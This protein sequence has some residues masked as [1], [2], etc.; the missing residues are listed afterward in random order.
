MTNSLVEK[1]AQEVLNDFNQYGFVK[2]S[3]VGSYRN[4]SGKLVH[5]LRITFDRQS[6]SKMFEKC[7]N[8]QNRTI[9]KPRVKQYRD[10]MLSN[11]WEDN[12]ESINLDEFGIIKNGHHRV[13]A[14][15]DLPDGKTI[16]LNVIL[17][18]NSNV[19]DQMRPRSLRD[20]GKLTGNELVIKYAPTINIISI[21]HFGG[22]FTI[23]ASNQA[24]LKVADIWFSEIKAAERFISKGIYM[25][26][27][28]PAT[29]AI[30]YASKAHS[31]NA[32]DFLDGVMGRVKG[33]IPNVDVNSPEGRCT[34][35]INNQES[36]SS[37]TDRQRQA[38]CALYYFREYLDGNKEIDEAPADDTRAL[39][40]CLTEFK[41]EVDA[42]I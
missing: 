39:K 27:A 25:K 31:Q 3:H 29:A 35:M 1:T 8:P 17:G 33:T 37:S 22:E 32:H 9:N 30:L 24:K 16:T 7:K 19:Y 11:N 4:D 20:Q 6:A 38:L 18:Y 42:V 2:S 28:V 23:T 21:C 14:I 40:Q 15:S 10:D 5:T 36:I 13:K 26:R 34:Y 12:G 41:S